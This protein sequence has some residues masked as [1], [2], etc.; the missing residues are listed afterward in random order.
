MSSEQGQAGSVR[1]P[2]VRLIRTPRDA[3]FAARD[4]LHYLGYSNAAVSPIGADGGVD[5]LSSRAV[6]QV[7]SGE[8]PTGRPIIQQIYGVAALREK[9]AIVFSVA[10]FTDEAMEWADRARVA[11]F[12][13]DLTGMAT[14]ANPRAESLYA[15]AVG[16]LMGWQAVRAELETLIQERRS[17]MIY[18]RFSIPDGYRG[19]WS[20][21]HAGNGKVFMSKDFAGSRERQVETVD[22]AVDILESKLRELGI[23]YWECETVIEVDGVSRPFQPRLHYP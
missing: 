4:W 1:K 17:A 23:Q 21:R 12:R 20:I 10:P 5:V 2:H 7:K 6:A 18:G 14:P 13:L 8:T 16:R 15:S 22:A 11:L 3:E 9:E 19:F